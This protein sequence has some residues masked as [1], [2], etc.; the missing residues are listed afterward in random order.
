MPEG[1][2]FGVGGID[3]A[4]DGSVYSGTRCAQVWRYEDASWLLFADGRVYEITMPGE[5]NAAGDEGLTNRS[6][7]DTLNRRR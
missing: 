5:L 7:Y 3:D 1:V 2:N 6:L 4:A